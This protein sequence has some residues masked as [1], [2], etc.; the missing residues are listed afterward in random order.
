V[1]KKNNKRSRSSLSPA[2]TPKKKRSRKS[3]EIEVEIVDEEEE[4]EGEEEVVEVSKGNKMPNKK[5]LRKFVQAYVT[6]FSMD[7]TTTK[8]LIQ[9]ASDKFDVNVSSKK[10]DILDLLAETMSD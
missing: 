1:G 2:K 5:E 7:K 3:E 8:H 6:C 4:E 9:T 10:K